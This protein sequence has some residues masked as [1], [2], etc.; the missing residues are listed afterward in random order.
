M[1]KSSAGKKKNSRRNRPADDNF[2][3]KAHQ[4]STNPDKR[5]KSK[6]AEVKK[7]QAVATK[8]YSEYAGLIASQLKKIE[9]P[10][11][12]LGWRVIKI[13]G[14][15]LWA[16]ASWL[17]AN[18]VVAFAVAIIRATTGYNLLSAS[19]VV[20]R[21]GIQGI[22]SAVMLFLAIGLPWLI[23]RHGT[24]WR[25]VLNSIGWKDHPS[26]DN[27]LR[28]MVVTV[29]YYITIVLAGYLVEWVAIAI[30]GHGVMS[31]VQDI[32]YS[33]A[34]N[35]WSQVI[36][37]LFLLV[38]ITPLAEETLFR[39]YLFGHI[40]QLTNFPVAAII[41]SLIFAVMHGQLNV[42]ITTF[43]LSMY[44]C[45]LREKTGSIWSSIGLHAIAN[46]VAAY[47]TYVMPML[48]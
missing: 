31:Q 47:L 41:V 35:N 13:I 24:T 21:V 3:S 11:L 9:M 20:M 36:A 6:L 45:Y 37:I 39:G 27:L 10:K 1:A 30:T 19:N 34:G 23:N 42:G 17:L 2:Q 33:T 18:I 43:A 40:R 14:W 22:I 7:E 4:P 32:G 16:V 48:G 25:D 38:A 26:T 12:T 8:E 46:G 29:A 5:I 15:C 44:S 28:L